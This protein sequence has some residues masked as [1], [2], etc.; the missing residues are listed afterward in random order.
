LDCPARAAKNFECFEHKR[1]GAEEN[2]FPGTE[3]ERPWR[4]A[5][6]F[7]QRKKEVSEGDRDPETDGNCIWEVTDKGMG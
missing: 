5:G 6:A 4:S 7:S 2:R 1:R 3:K